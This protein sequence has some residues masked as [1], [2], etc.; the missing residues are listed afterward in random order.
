MPLLTRLPQATHSLRHVTCPRYQ[1]L[2]GLASFRALNSAP[3]EWRRPNVACSHD[4]LPI[5]EDS[6]ASQDALKRVRATMPSWLNQRLATYGPYVYVASS[7]CIN[8]CIGTGLHLVGTSIFSAV[9]L[10]NIFSSKRARD[11]IRK[12][13]GP[14]AVGITQRRWENSPDGRDSAYGC[15]Q[16]AHWT[17][18]TTFIT[19]AL[20]PGVVS[21][22]VSSSMMNMLRPKRRE[23]MWFWKAADPTGKSQKNGKSEALAEI[24]SLSTAF[25][26]VAGTLRAYIA[27][28]RKGVAVACD[29][30]IET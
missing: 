18:A 26:L 21:T 24:L 13:Q 17:L 23:S 15:L 5:D 20:I 1:I 4:Q 9:Y 7:L 12:T 11:L 25:M 6:R 10:H 22:I 16:D 2:R 19:L 27:G 3:V 14:A 29:A 28:W 8:S 30:A